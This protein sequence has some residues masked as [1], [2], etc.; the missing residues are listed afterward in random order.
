MRPSKWTPAEVACEL[1][2]IGLGKYA[3]DFMESN[4]SGPDLF[5]VTETEL[6]NIGMTVT[7]R[8]TFQQFIKSLPPSRVKNPAP[9]RLHK[10]LKVRPDFDLPTANT[11]L[12]HTSQQTKP[13]FRTTD[14]RISGPRN[15]TKYNRNVIGKKA[16]T[17]AQE[18]DDF[19]IHELDFTPPP[20]VNKIPK[21]INQL[22]GKGPKIPEEGSTDNRVACRFCGRKFASDRIDV[23]ER[24]CGHTK[25]RTVFNSAKQRISRAELELLMRMQKKNAA[26]KAAA[27]K[28]QKKTINGKPK[29]KIEHENLVAA[30]RAARGASLYEKGKIKKMPSVPQMQELPDERVQCPYCKRRFGHEQAER[31]IPSCKNQYLIKPRQPRIRK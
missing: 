30:L 19:D 29:Y 24:I 6:R 8:S 2:N 3:R 17:F 22:K 21:R 31:H 16:C 20:R 13:S 25:K 18:E 12:A 14:T 26:A 5:S 7:A 10:C 4:I 28:T 15:T 27:S 11:E 23:H 9:N 1:R